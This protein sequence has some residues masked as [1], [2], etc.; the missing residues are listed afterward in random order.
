MLLA[1]CGATQLARETNGHGR[2]SA[3]LLKLLNQ[4]PPDNL[5]YSKIISYLNLDPIPEYIPLLLVLYHQLMISFYL[6]DRILNAKGSIWIGYYL[7]TRSTSHD[8]SWCL[9]PMIGIQTNTSHL[10]SKRNSP[11]TKRQ[12]S[13]LRMRLT[14]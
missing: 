5:H 3:S 1:A 14:S 11:F 12:M 6:T 8:T 2:F 10:N 9:F 4:I 7:M 13:N